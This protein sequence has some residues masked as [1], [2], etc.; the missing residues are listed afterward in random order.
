[1]LMPFMM[2]GHFAPLNRFLCP[3]ARESIC[4]LNN[5]SLMRMQMV[6]LITGLGSKNCPAGGT[7]TFLAAPKGTGKLV[8]QCLE[9]FA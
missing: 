6:V 9:L 5:A 4:A 3:K 7:E 8:S 1:M 2:G